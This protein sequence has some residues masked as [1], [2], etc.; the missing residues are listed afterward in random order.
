MSETMKYADVRLGT[1]EAV[2]NKLGG[3]EGVE[4]FLR[5]DAEVTIKRHVI[6]CDADPHCPD[7]WTV[8][9]H[10]KGGQF[11][12]NPD[13]VSLHLDEGQQDGRVIKGNELRKKLAKQPVL[14]SCVLDYLLANPQLIPDE[15]KSKL[16]FFWG[17]IYRSSGGRLYVR[18]LYWGGGR[19]YWS[20]RW[21]GN[22]WR[23]RSP[24]AVRAS[25]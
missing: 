25:N 13:A 3:I 5:G 8:E 23:G 18:C 20:Y 16:V 1:V 6:N 22:D 11:E 4:R 19:W 21:L 12:W 15:W 7:G 9:E 2:F 17:T 14:N 24:A 10:T